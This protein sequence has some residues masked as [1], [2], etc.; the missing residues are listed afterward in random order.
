MRIN[1][2]IEYRDFLARMPVKESLTEDGSTRIEPTIGLS[3][4]GQRVSLWGQRNA[5]Q[6]WRRREAGNAF[7]TFLKEKAQAQGC[8]ENSTE[9]LIWSQN[10]LDEFLAQEKARK[11]ARKGKGKVREDSEEEVLEEDE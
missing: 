8:P 3:A 1:S 7:A 9:G 6:T 10:D 11:T 5:V 2:R 4:L